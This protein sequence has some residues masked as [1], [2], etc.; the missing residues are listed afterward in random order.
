MKS[1][2][3]LRFFYSFS[4]SDTPEYLEAMVMKYWD[5]DIDDADHKFTLCLQ[6]PQTTML[7]LNDD[8]DIRVSVRVPEERWTVHGLW[9]RGDGPFPK[10]A[11]SY[12]PGDLST[13]WPSFHPKWT[14]SD[15]F[16]HEW[17]KH[18][19]KHF[20]GQKEYHDTIAELTQRRRFDVFHL[21]KERGIL[22]DG[23]GYPGKS[24]R[25]ALARDER[26]LGSVVLT[27]LS[28]MMKGQPQFLQEVRFCLNA[29]FE[30]T[31]CFTSIWEGFSC[32]HGDSEIIYPKR[33]Y[34]DV[35]SQSLSWSRWK[36]WPV[37]G[38]PK[39]STPRLA[40]VCG[41]NERV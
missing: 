29:K 9:L 38:K 28:T 20:R 39:W 33:E 25:W 27:C 1:L 6:W 34:C 18:G 36:R 22:P 12:N 31:P 14:S 40:M 8:K 4:C 37:Y 21:L 23:R 17:D 26:N 16:Q 13:L 24:V 15:F 32:P 35:Y 10:L 7:A 3:W 19:I 5:A 2:A 30:L 11:E 41:R